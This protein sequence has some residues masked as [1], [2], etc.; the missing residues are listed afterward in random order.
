MAKVRL[1]PFEKSLSRLQ[2]VGW[3]VMRKL[4]AFLRRSH[5]A[6][7]AG[8]STGTLQAVLMATVVGFGVAALPQDANARNIVSVS[9]HVAPGTVVISASQRRLF[10]VV[11][12]G[13]AI[14]YPVAVPKR[15]KEWSGATSIEGKYVNPDW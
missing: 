8:T 2:H 14:S 4:F 9:P 3:S 12:T 10:Y 7:S 1:P 11:D 5:T 6:K 15:G 13:V